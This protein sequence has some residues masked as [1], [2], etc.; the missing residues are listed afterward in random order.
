MRVTL[1]GTD[2]PWLEAKLDANG[3]VLVVMD[4]FSI[5][6]ATAPSLGSEF[7]VELSATTDDDCSWEG[8]FSGNPG[9]RRTIERV[10]SWKY[11]AFGEVT[12]INPVS[13][14]CGLLMVDDVF[15]SNDPRVVG[16]FIAFTISRL[17]AVG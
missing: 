4:E 9:R 10:D 16:E 3:Q 1:I 12:S 15:S 2:G 14:D 8:M 11:R 5:N 6:E 7:E 13:V 17:C